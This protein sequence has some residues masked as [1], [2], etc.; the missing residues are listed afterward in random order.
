[1]CCECARWKVVVRRR[2]KR[3]LFGKCAVAIFYIIANKI[4]NQNP[5]NLTYL[6]ITN[7]DPHPYRPLDLVPSLPRNP[8]HPIFD[9]APTERHYQS[10]QEKHE[11]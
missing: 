1:M 5:T 7:L 11:S 3:V 2:C 6:Y 8:S 9:I 10:R 4:Y